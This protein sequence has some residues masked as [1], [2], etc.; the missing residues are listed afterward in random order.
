MK[1]AGKWQRCH[2]SGSRVQW[3][4]TTAQVDGVDVEGKETSSM[5][6]E[7]QRRAV[8]SDERLEIASGFNFTAD[9][10]FL[11]IFTLI[12]DNSVLVTQ[13]YSQNFQKLSTSWIEFLTLILKIAVI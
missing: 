12:I 8:H 6:D 11:H 2:C 7:G 5:I 3:Q 13:S 10:A 1:L 4:K 9:V